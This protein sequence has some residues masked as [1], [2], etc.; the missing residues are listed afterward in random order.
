[1]FTAKAPHA[2]F[3]KSLTSVVTRGLWRRE[4]G[5][6]A[7]AQDLRLA[8]CFMTS[9]SS[10]Q[11]PG[12]NSTALAFLQ[13]G[14][15]VGSGWGIFGWGRGWAKVITWCKL[16]H[17][18]WLQQH[19]VRST[20]NMASSNQPWAV[21]LE[22]LIKA[23]INSKGLSCRRVINACRCVHTPGLNRLYHM[24]PA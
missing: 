11:T 18:G 14:S 12:G 16:T 5:R 10:H 9:S 6:I 13:A 3:I 24:L 19:R 22:I 8:H 15:A 17:F 7:P 21:L 4:R 23:G 20:T 2:V 1:M